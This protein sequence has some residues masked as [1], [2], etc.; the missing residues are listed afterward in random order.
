[1]RQARVD[2][3]LFHFL[4]FCQHGLFVGTV[5]MLPV[6]PPPKKKHAETGHEKKGAGE[7]GSGQ[8]FPAAPQGTHDC[9]PSTPILNLLPYITPSMTTSSNE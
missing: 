2:T 8:G 6:T 1:M 4:L 5:D 7:Q 9:K 3:L